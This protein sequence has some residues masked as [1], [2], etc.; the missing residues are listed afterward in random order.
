MPVTRSTP[1]RSVLVFVGLFLVTGM[2]M[3]MGAVIRLTMGVVMGTP[4]CMAVI[5]LMLMLMGMDMLVAVGMAVGSPLVG[6]GM[7]VLMAVFVFVIVG[8][9]VFSFHGS[10]L[11]QLNNSFF[12][13]SLEEIK[14]FCNY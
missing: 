9:F 3:L 12:C 11:S 7:I 10:L 4:G 14:L 5:M 8:M 1:G 6:M 2:G 13:L